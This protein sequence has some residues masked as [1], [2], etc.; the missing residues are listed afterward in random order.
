MEKVIIVTGGSTG[1]GKCLSKQLHTKFGYKVILVGRSLKKLIAA[2]KELTEEGFLCSIYSLDVTDEEKV[3][4]FSKEI[5][6]KY[7]IYGL[8]NNAGVGIF[9][10]FEQTTKE[11]LE[12]MFQTNVVGTYLPTK[13]LLPFMTEG[14]VMNIISTAGLVGKTNETLY[15]ASKFAQRGLVES[16]QSE[17]AESN[18]HIQAVYMGGMDTPFWDGSTHIKDKTNLASPCKVA[19]YIVSNFD[20]K[21]IVVPGKDEL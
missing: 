7:S 19:A 8:V 12:E 16:L 18:V 6:E 21:A 20:S 3:S 1:L 10:P 17:Y 13:Y 14:F 9:G 2:E 15:C 4:A 11:Q 5:N